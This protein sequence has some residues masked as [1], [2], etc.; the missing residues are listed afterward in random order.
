M[1]VEREDDVDVGR[2]A[3]VGGGDLGRGSGCWVGDL[4]GSRGGG[5]V[6]DEYA[7]DDDLG[8]VK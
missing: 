5:A 1:D 7:D 4:D 8:E 3:K 2:G 6:V